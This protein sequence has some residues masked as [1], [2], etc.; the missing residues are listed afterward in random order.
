MG[1][2]AFDREIENPG[3][4]GSPRLRLD[5]LVE[6]AGTVVAIGAGAATHTSGNDVVTFEAGGLVTRVE[7]YV[8]PFG[9]E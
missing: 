4:T 9:Q 8:V 2:E 1:K 7:S 3:F 6:E 5:R